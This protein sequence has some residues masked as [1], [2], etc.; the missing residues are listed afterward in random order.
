MTTSSSRAAVAS[1]L[2]GLALTGCATALSP[3]N[4]ADAARVLITIDAAL[5]RDCAFMGIASADND[6]DLQRKAAWIGGDVVVVTRE[7]QE[8]RASTAWY[9]SVTSTTEVFRCEGTR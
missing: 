9:R 1:G 6:K 2:I 8:A 5:A 4:D 7:S 3:E